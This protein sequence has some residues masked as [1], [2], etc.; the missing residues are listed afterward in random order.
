MRYWYAR[1]LL[2]RNASGDRDRAQA[3]LAEARS[4]SEDMGMHGLIGRIDELVP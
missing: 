1:M 4:L 3:L 2:D